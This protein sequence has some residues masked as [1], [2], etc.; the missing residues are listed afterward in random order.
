MNA[1]EISIP[2]LRYSVMADW[3]E[4]MGADSALLVFVG[5]GSSK[6]RQA[7][8]VTTIAQR[9]NAHALVVD[10]S[11][12]GKSLF[13]MDETM[14]AQHLMEAVL[15]YDWLAVKHPELSICVMGTSYGGFIAGYL[16]RFRM[17]ER[18][19]LRTPAIYRPEDFYTLHQYIDKTAARFYR[20]ETE[21]LRHHPLFVQ[22]ALGT[23]KTLVVVH[24][25]DESVPPE[26]TDLFIDNFDAASYLAE[27][28]VHRFRDPSNPQDAVDSYYRALVDWLA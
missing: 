7:E 17:I 16:S 20:T 4:N 13:A 6:E 25:E 14:P 15:V 11:G 2:I 19:V 5:F 28:F 24:G 12:Q 27:G 22:P 23:P 8:F 9:A 26:T 3:Y 10:L 1:Q 18:L 21:L